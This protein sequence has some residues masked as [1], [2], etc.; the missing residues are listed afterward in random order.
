M[1][2]VA[3]LIADHDRVRGLFARY[4][5][6]HDSGDVDEAAKLVAKIVE[7]LAVHMAIEEEVFYPAI[8]ELKHEIGESVDEGLEE[9]HLA[10]V[11]IEELGS[12]EPTD[13]SW[14]AKVTVLIESVEHHVDEEEEE[15]FPRVRGASNVAWR[16]VLAD[17]LE[18]R[19][20]ELGAP[21]LADKIDMPM[22]ELEA[23]A[24]AQK[25]PGRSSMDQ[26]QLAATVS[27]R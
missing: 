19:K 18:A 16:K 23:L 17:K 7:E 21:V 5:D 4:E 14:V 15:L 25:I 20:K 9:H 1:D 22:S 8:H 13:E 2:A 26:E 10:K 3:L 27:P 24:R 6:A 12:L 11:L